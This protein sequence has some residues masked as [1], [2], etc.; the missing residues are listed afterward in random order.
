MSQTIEMIRTRAPKK[1]IAMAALYNTP[2]VIRELNNRSLYHF[3]QHFFHIVSPHQFQPN[4][5][6]EYLC[7][8]LEILA[9][10]VAKKQ[11]REYDLIVNVPP[12]STK[13][14]TCS[15]MF[16]AWCWTKWPWM[17]FITSSYSA[18]LSLE[19]AEYCR[20]LIRSTE[21]QQLYPELDIASDKDVK[22]NYKITVRD[23][24]NNGKQM[25]LTKAGSR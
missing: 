15:I 1:Q 24:V 17:R 4:W 3:L 6:I 21:F 5:H 14:I 13:T 9:E 18:T 10:R 8:E 7:Q 19:S 25:R 23:F 2:A 16:P 12:G 22:S 11:P 20:D